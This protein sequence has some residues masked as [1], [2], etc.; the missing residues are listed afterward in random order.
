MSFIFLS[1]IAGILTILAPC[2]FTLLPV[3][4]GGSAAGQN[5]WR[6]FVIIAS[7]SISILLFTLLLKV[8]TIFLNVNPLFWQIVSGGILISFGL[9]SLFPDIWN[10][11]SLKLNLARSS[12]SLLEKAKEKE[13]FWGAVLLGASL[14]PVFSSCSPTYA[15]IIST[16]FRTNLTEAIINMVVYV[17][18][19]ALVMSL[20]AFLGQ[21][22]IKKLR[23]AVNPKGLFKRILGV[24]FI[25]IGIAVIGGYDKQLQT[26]IVENGTF[27]VTRVEKTLLNENK[28]IK[29]DPVGL[30]KSEE[31]KS[32]PELAGI[33]GWINSDG[34]KIA[35]LKGKVVL[36]D[37]WTY[38]CINCKRTQPYLNK[39]YDSYKDKGFEILGVHAPEFTF[40][41]KLD[42]VQN[43]VNNAKIQYP[44]GLDNDFK[45]WNAYD[46]AF[47]PAKYL[48]D[49][50][51]K[52]RYIHAG[53]GK[54]EETEDIIRTLLEESGA[55]IDSKN[56]SQDI[57]TT[58][59]ASRNQTPETYL[60]WSRSNT[61]FLNLSELNSTQNFNK[62]AK[63]SSKELNSNSWT[64]SGDWIINNESIT[65]NS[66][67]AVLKFKYNAKEVYLVAGNEGNP[68]SIKITSGGEDLTKLNKTILGS[69]VN[70]NSE[71]KI[72]SDRM[73][74]L[75]KLDKF[76][77]NQEIE[78]KVPKGLRL[79]VFTFGS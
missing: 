22:L 18:G 11:I 24:I 21:R 70:Q 55:K 59:G 74:R 73:Y 30:I 36:V 41:K 15:I 17:I 67:D 79:N 43:A 34:E 54:Y 51:G 56:T 38:S 7:L 29:T 63:Y 5:K 69:D 77:E 13:G 62:S 49:K 46:N 1:F 26:L 33:Q 52:I 58:E 31:A 76:E 60:G 61:S 10:Q 68:Q 16:T 12:D 47:W 42:N 45:T 23:W 53:E 44:V 65:A 66:G 14:G 25:L 4:V 27:D 75:I 3:I 57:T 6:P 19:I 9:I 8:S 39:W 78:L 32:A 40:E 71:I 64:L 28:I 72:D 2:S 37:F 35:D 20:V 48:I 50:D